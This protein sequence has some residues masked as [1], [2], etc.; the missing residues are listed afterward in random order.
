MRHLFLAIVL[1]GALSLAVTAAMA[2]GPP[3][4]NQ[5]DH[6]I[7]EALV[8]EVGTNC[9]TGQP[10]LITGSFS[11]VIHTLVKADGTVHINGS[12]RGSATNDDDLVAG[13]I[14]DASTTFTS[15]FIDIF[16]AS[17]GEKHKFTLNGTGTTTATGDR[18]RFHVLIQTLI[19]NNGD[20][21]IDFIQ[22][23]CF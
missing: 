11:G 4:F 9:G 6:V 20:L 23:R 12:V 13:G 22:F 17:G 8:P 5:S 21:K 16:R 1:V 3:V 14:P 19:D 10:T 15:N 7:N 18:F 2:G